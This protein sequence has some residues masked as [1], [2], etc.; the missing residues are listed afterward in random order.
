MTRS[1][2]LSTV[3]ALAVAL[4][5]GACG[6]KKPEVPAPAPPPPPVEKTTPAPPP[7]PPPPPPKPAP[8]PLSEEEIFSRMTLDE[9]NAKRPLGDVFFAYDSVTIM[10][11]ARTALQTNF[12]YLKRWA[13]TK[14]MIEG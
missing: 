3:L 2:C 11:E 5:V 10:P 1:A 14:V 7:P 12:E 8:A 6:K 13:S 9:L 4:T